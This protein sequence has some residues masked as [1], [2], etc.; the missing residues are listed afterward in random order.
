MAETV[1]TIGARRGLHGRPAALFAVRASRPDARAIE[2]ARADE[3]AAT[4]YPAHSVIDLLALDLARGER[5]AL[6]T[7][8]TDAEPVLKELVAMLES[9]LDDGGHGP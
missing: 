5:I 1:A 9:D 3:P 7:V 2:V 4:W 8:R 6:R